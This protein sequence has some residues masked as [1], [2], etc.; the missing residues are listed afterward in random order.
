MLVNDQE[1]PSRRLPLIDAGGFSIPLCGCKRYYAKWK[2][3]DPIFTDSE[4]ILMSD[5]TLCRFVSI[6]LL[7]PLCFQPVS[8]VLS[9]VIFRVVAKHNRPLSS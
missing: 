2:T 7:G 5:C 6:R 4:D 3:V 1:W 9:A 8:E